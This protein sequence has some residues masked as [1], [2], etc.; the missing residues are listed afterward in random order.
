MSAFDAFRSRGSKERRA[1]AR[2]EAAGSPIEAY[3]EMDE[4]AV[5]ADLS[6]RSQDELAEVETRERSNGSRAAVLNK[7]RYMRGKEPFRGYDELDASGVVAALGDVD[8]ETL[9]KVR[10]YERK[11]RGR[12][13]VLDE[14]DTVLRRRLAE[15]ESAPG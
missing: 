11:F 14:V 5:V 3:D 4:K 1:A 2:H 10:T 9:G 12:R 6:H 15:K 13:E 8:L 7:L